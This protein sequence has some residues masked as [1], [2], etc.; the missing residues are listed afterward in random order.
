MA[1]RGFAA[2]AAALMLL[3]IAACGDDDDGGSAATT[4][5]GGAATTAAG[6]A[7]TA[8]GGAA[9]DPIVIG[10]AVAQS[11]GFEL[12]DNEVIKGM[13]YLMDKINAEG[14]VDGRMFELVVAD[15]KTD[16]AQVESATQDVLSQGADVVVTTAD[17]DFGAAAALAAQQAGKVSMGGARAVQFGKSG[18][19]PMHFNV[20]QGTSTEAAVMAQFAMDQGYEK[21]YLLSD[22][23]IEYSK[24]VC[25]LFEKAWTALGGEIAG[26]QTFLSSD[27]SIANQISAVKDSD[28][29]SVIMCSYP[30]GGASAIRQLRTSGVDLPI[31]GGAAFDGTFWLE[32]IPDLSDFYYPTMVSSAG[33]DPNPDVNEF[34]AA[35]DPAGGAIYSLFGYSIIESVA[36]ALEMNGGNADGTALAEALQTFKDQPLLVGPTTYTADCHV[37]LGRPMA[38]LQIQD[39][40]PSFIEYSTPEELPDTT[41]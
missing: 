13:E 10:A 35:V 5:A 23:S 33:D 24:T 36:A 27:P 15:H 28:A 18:L 26:K 22:T 32:A 4:A 11:G 16:P 6:G 14:G 7:T 34:L 9:G 31:V 39:G 37:P 40:K 19:G 8:A 20:F 21:P 12:Y 17:Y 29:D 41:C 30:P 1:R 2:A 25:D 3:G 38:V